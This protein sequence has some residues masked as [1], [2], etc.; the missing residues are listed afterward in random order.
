MP[1]PRNIE[2]VQTLAFALF[3]LALVAGSSPRATGDGGEY[4]AMAL[5]IGASGSPSLTA[6]DVDR[7]RERLSSVDGLSQ[8]DVVS[9]A[10]VS[11]YGTS[12]FVH[13]WFYSALATPFVQ[14]CDLL[15]VNPV[16]GFTAL[17]LLMLVLSFCL[18][19]PRIGPAMAW[20][21]WA[22]PVLWWIDKPHTEV[23]TFSLLATAVLLLAESP[24]WSFAA[25]G[26]AATQNPPLFI[27]LPIAMLALA[28]A[29]Q[30]PR[31]S[32][33][34]W[35]GAGAG[36]A[37]FGAHVLYYQLRHGTPFLLLGAATRTFPSPAEL[38]V[39]PFD[40]SLG[41]AP[42]FPAFTLLVAAAAVIVLSRPR[43]WLAPDL[44]LAI[45]VL[46][47][48]L[49]S[50]TQT[51]NVHH[52]GTPGLS[53]YAIWLVPLAL[54]LV[55]A[56]RLARPG[57][58]DKLA[59]LLAVPSVIACAL[60]FHPRHPD[61]YREPTWLSQYLWTRHP[62][63]TNPLPEIFADVLMPGA[64]PTL[65]VATA[66]C[67]KVL[68]VGRGEAQGMWPMPCYP[69]EVPP[70]C[71]Q[72]AALCYANRTR[73]GY[74]FV[75][76]RDPAGP[77]FKFA[78]DRTWSLTAEPFVRRALDDLGWLR[79]RPGGERSIVRASRE[80]GLVESLESPD[81]LFLAVVRTGANPQ[82]DLQ[83]GSKFSGTYLD[84]ETGAELGPATLRESAQA[85]QLAVPAN[86]SVVLVVL[87]RLPD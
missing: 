45:G 13:F 17:N 24:G 6:A 69:A 36:C 19:L 31:R 56:L 9:S 84:P 39:V 7:I 49:V 20:L 80:I 58:S 82:I 1:R 50:F 42:A 44:L 55:R 62:S 4:L 79:V 51:S 41:I 15:G 27:A 14:A 83:M 8:W 28:V 33:A 53:R 57:W 77:R 37:L 59:L 32:P 72:P 71:R 67:E 73:E 70:E 5:D 48:L 21:L 64:E 26:A 46:P 22:G 85:S 74:R 78:R 52:G 76:T 65:P 86:R 3:L 75:P 12:D 23:F 34:A 16:Y 25:I 18:A 81:R 29:R 11:R 54:P 35:I 47:F 61:N 10:H 2:R 30:F 87:R 60:V 43:L 66:T 68:L 40:S 38:L 63:L